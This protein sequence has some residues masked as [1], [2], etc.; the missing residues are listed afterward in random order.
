MGVV[1]GV[2]MLPTVE[3]AKVD[4]VTDGLLTEV[5]GFLSPKNKNN[6]LYEI[7]IK[8]SPYQ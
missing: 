4:E 6:C 2:V 3:V 1:V 5:G 7:K 8:I